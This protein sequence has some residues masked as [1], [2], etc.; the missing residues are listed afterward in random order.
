MALNFPNSPTLN[1][2]HTENGTTWKWNGDSWT[3]VLTTGAAGAQGAQGAAGSAGSTGAQG[4]AGSD[5]AQGA[6]GTGATGA[7][8]AAGSDGAQGASGAQGAAG[9]GGGGGSI[10]GINTTGTSYFNIID[11]PIPEHRVPII[12]AGGTI[13][14]FPGFTYQSGNLRVQEG[15][16]NIVAGGEVS[17][18]S[19]SVS[20]NSILTGD[21]N[22][23]TGEFTVGT[24]NE[25][26]ISNVGVATFAGLS[27]TGIST[28]GDLKVDGTTIESS[29]QINLVT[30]GSAFT[31]D[32]NTTDAI[33]AGGQGASQYVQLYGAG[34]EKIR[35]AGYGVTVTGTTFSN[36]L[37]VSGVITATTFSGSGASLTN[38]P[39]ANLTGTLPAISGANLTNL[40]SDTPA[41]TDV[42]VTWTVTA[43]GSSAYRFTG[44]GNDASDDNPD[45]YLVRGQRYRFT[46][47]SGGSHPFQIRSSAGGSAYSTGVTNN[48]ASS[49]NI[50]FNVQHDAPA[51]LYYQC[52]SHSGM[53]GNI[54]I[55]GGGQWQN[56]SVAASGTPEVYTDYSVG[57][58]TDN[59]SRGPLHIH[60]N[61]AD[62]YFHVTN[63]TTGS[64]TG[65]G[66][67]M[68]QSG[69]E[70]LLVNRE[71]G[72]MRLYTAGTERLRIRSDG[73]ISAGTNFNATNTYEFSI[74]G[75]DG[76][77]GFYAHGR[78]HY[79]S[80][81]SNAYSSLTL[82]KANADSD[83]IDYLQ[84]RDS[85]NNLK[86]S[87]TGAGNWKPISGG[88]IDFSATSDGGTGTPSELL[89]DY[90]EG[91]F[92]PTIAAGADNGSGGTVPFA[93][94]AGRYIKIGKKVHC[95][96]YFRFA[97]GAYSTGSHA[98]IGNLPFA[99][100][101][102]S[103]GNV[104]ASN[105]TRGGGV[106][107]FQNTTS[108]ITTC[109]GN[110]NT[111]YFY[112]YKDGGT[113]FIFGGANDAGL[114][115][116][117]WIGIFEYVSNV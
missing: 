80:N 8:G 100:S 42:Q 66:F 85:S 72:N 102:D 79:L 30:N 63:A 28:L 74:T 16:G 76:T 77:G 25:A 10:A 51:R 26:F 113:N 23:A 41:D 67:T 15:S 48:G 78:N 99:I 37:S 90:E 117:Y 61:S 68:H 1:Q 43:N 27:V 33:I 31:L 114:S 105:L 20:G 53:V 104:G 107:T 115:G 101:N 88:G 40:P 91:F 13:S 82:K 11:T 21:V 103:Y 94:Q 65:D 84:L 95:D 96:I 86:A 75:A 54:Y 97:S 18:S 35:T 106:S 12:G 93:I 98:R 57:I 32:I 71:S 34:S 14:H 83:A 2:Q 112:L 81:R 6:T 5:G 52:T 92:T 38:L 49:G 46:N 60:S 62:T 89:D 109:Y 24:Q 56:Q 111:A 108:D 55:T 59:V 110:S 45:L 73:K 7:Q 36:Q 58:G 70:S 17:S 44:P 39:A 69:V 9:G 87:I 116:T 50:D 22:V 3:R 4:A 64:G 19:L 29:G 47:N